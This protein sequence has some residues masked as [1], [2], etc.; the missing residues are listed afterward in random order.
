MTP[1][2]GITGRL[3]DVG[4][5]PHAGVNAAYVSAVAAAGGIPLVLPPSVPATSTG[6]LAAGLDGLLISGGADIDPARYGATPHPKLGTLEPDRDAFEIAMLDAARARGLPVLAI[7]RGMQVV[8][9]ALGGTL[10][11]DLPSE[12]PGDV[13]HDGTWARTARV[14]AVEI[15]AGSALARS[16][17]A[18]SVTVNSFHHQGVRRL[19]AGL[20]PTAA[21]PDGLVEGFESDHGPWLVGVQWHPEAFHAEADSPDVRLFQSFVQACALRPAGAAA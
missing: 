6:A 5:Q 14:H 9:V 8:N 19:A 2:I 11:Q 17:G 1:R 21:A 7:C 12:R 18:G 10:W 16:V 13:R 4:G 20:A 3:R 15:V